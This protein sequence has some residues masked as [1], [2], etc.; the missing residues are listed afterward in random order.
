MFLMPFPYVKSATIK[1]NTIE[2][3]VELDYPDSGSYLE[4]SGS[5]T[6]T[7]G[8]YANFYTIGEAIPV[9][10]DP[11]DPKEPRPTIN[12]SAH[13]LPPNNFRKGEDVTFVIRV[14]KVWLTVLG[15]GPRPVSQA[16]EP[17][18]EGTTWDSLRRWSRVSTG[19]TDDPQGDSFR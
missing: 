6:Q 10:A 12:V 17:A 9:R 8:A 18:V 4:V 15:H 1:N 16:G 5:A 7:G 11:S 2:L 19:F 3:T 13:P 14:A